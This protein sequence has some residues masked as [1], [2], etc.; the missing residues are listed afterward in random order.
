[1]DQNCVAVTKA[2]VLPKRSKKEKYQETIKYLK[3]HKWLYLML[4]PG[5]VYLIVF[6]YIPMGGIIIAFQNIIHIQYI[7]KRVG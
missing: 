3:Q 1:M 2:N 4:I 6:R 7:R 5:L